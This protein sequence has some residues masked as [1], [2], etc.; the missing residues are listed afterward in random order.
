M[1]RQIL[2]AVPG[3][4]VAVK[5]RPG[6]G[7]VH[8]GPHQ[9]GSSGKLILHGPE[10]P[11]EGMGPVNRRFR[12]FRQRVIVGQAV[13]LE[14]LQSGGHLLQVI[15]LGPMFITGALALGDALL[16]VNGEIDPLPG[17]RASAAL[18]DRPGRSSAVND[19][20]HILRAVAAAQR[21]APPAGGP[22]L[23]GEPERNHAAPPVKHLNAGLF[24][25]REK[26]REI[27][28]LLGKGPINGR[29]HL[30]FERWFTGRAQPLPIVQKFPLAV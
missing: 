11:G 17:G 7:I 9:R 16:N 22:V 25:Q 29:P 1:R 4:L 6:L 13:L 20:L 12:F 5:H 10:L 2:F 3:R 15:E 23:A 21:G 24:H 27:A 26:G 18:K 28:G 8:H 19:G 14:I 30:F